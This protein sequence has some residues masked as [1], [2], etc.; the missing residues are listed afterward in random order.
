LGTDDWTLCGDLG[1]IAPSLA[2][3]L[4]GMLEELDSFASDIF[5]HT[6]TEMP[7]GVLGFPPRCNFYS[8]RVAHRLQ[9]FAPRICNLFAQAPLF[10]AFLFLQ[11]FL[12]FQLSPCFFFLED[13][14]PFSPWTVPW[15]KRSMEVYEMRVNLLIFFSSRFIDL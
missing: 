1:E 13:N 4:E 10:L 3:S 9:S 8:G 14:G 11:H 6:G 2:P 15:T 5:A 12:K 7:Y